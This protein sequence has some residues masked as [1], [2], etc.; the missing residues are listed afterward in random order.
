M[1]PHKPA[2][3]GDL[4]APAWSP[5]TETR[6]DVKALLR[7]RTQLVP[8]EVLLFH[9]LYSD[10]YD[11]FF[12]TL[13]CVV[14]SRGATDANELDLVHDALTAFWDETLTQGFPSSI[15]AKLLSLAGGLTRN[16]V[17]HER[18]NP[19]TEAMPTSS[20]ET[21]GSFPRPDR[22]LDLK[23]MARGLFDRLSPQH[24]AIIDAVIFRDL[25]VG[26][27]A[28]EIGLREKTAASR[29]TAALTLLREWTDELLSA[30]ERRL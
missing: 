10:I 19:A 22:A 3:E 21:P 27:A 13:R 14:R 29:L 2:D 7:R 11:R 15:Q 18:L 9:A 28:L 1:S 23:K 20:Q 16:H 5:E 30:S 25:T 24:Q 4:H 17:R 6:E 26:A 8:D 12:K